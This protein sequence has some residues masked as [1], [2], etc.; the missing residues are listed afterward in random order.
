MSAYYSLLLLQQDDENH[1]PSESEKLKLPV[2][3]LLSFICF[4]NQ[5]QDGSLSMTTSV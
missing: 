5:I 4:R 1:T 3:L 2:L